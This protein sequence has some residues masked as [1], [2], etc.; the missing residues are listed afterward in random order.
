[1]NYGEKL[2]E[3]RL[4]NNYSQADIAKN[5]NVSR[6]TYS[7]YEVQ[8]KIIPVTRLN[9]ISNYYD[10]SID[11]ILGLNNLF[12]YKNSNKNI[13]KEKLSIRLKEFRKDKNLTQIKLANILNIANGTIA[14][15]ER[16]TNI[17]ATPFLYDICK[18][19]HISADYLLGK[20]DNPK[21]LK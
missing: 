3:L 4:N 20:I 11:Y 17:I 13:N 9:D 1:M 15:Y 18:K 10:T 6:I 12:Q 19:Y 16:G 21:Y 2:K 5:L 7:H 8:E 14:E